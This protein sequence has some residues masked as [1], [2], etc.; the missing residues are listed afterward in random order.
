[1]DVTTL[2]QQITSKTPAMVYLALGT[3]QVLLQQVREMFINLIPKEERVMNVGS[4]DM[5][6][7]PLAVA[8]DDAMATPFFGER[9]LVLVN[10]PYFFT[11]EKGPAKIDH[12]LESLSNYLQHPEPSTILVFLAPYE[13]LDGRKKI[14]KELKKAAV[15]IDT[16]PLD[17]A[18]ARRQ[19]QNSLADDKYTIDNEAIDELVQ[20][21]N[22]D[23]ELM[24]A[25]LS[26]LKL[27]TYQDRHITK[28][29]VQDLV[30]QSLDENVFDLVNAVLRHDQ[31]KSIDLYD[32]LIAGQQ[33][34]LRIN[35]VLIS[36]FRLLLQIKVLSSRGLSQGSLAQKLRVH[37]YRVK[38][39]LRTVRQFSLLALENAY[40]GLVNIE[41]ALKTT[42]R[43]PRLLFQLFMLQYGQQQKISM[44]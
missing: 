39:G 44:V 37:P 22:A 21:T 40:L 36:Q 32:Q 41:K 19:V 7:T 16:A 4:Y 17:E 27:L 24:N 9:R 12:D 29:A 31:T 30:P 10:K 11:G 8:L 1:M 28:Q 15:M 23:Y 42:Q 43:D 33:P 3:Q 13:K 6:T 2:K 14:V 38:L 34:P 25:N 5:E 35:A 18:H 20:R 26:K